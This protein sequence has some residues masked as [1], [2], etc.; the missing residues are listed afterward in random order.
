[1]MTV[2]FPA[3]AKGCFET[4]IDLANLKI[5]DVSELLELVLGDLSAT[6]ES[7]GYSKNFIE[8]MGLMVIG[9]VFISTFLILGFIVFKVLKKV[10]FVQKAATFL[11][12]KLLF[13]MFIRTFIATYLANAIAAFYALYFLVYERTI[14]IVSSVSAI[15]MSVLV[16]GA[17]VAILLFVSKYMARLDEPKVKNR[18][19]SIY[20]GLKMNS[21]QTLIYNFYFVTRRLL[22]AGVI[23]SFGWFPAF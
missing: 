7:G 17:P 19:G 22:I 8:S 21:F 20:F 2:A 4:I 3:N 18:V 23:V 14:D 1:M 10:P 5:F 15:L 9:L 6:K 12:N 16:I 11:A 13:N